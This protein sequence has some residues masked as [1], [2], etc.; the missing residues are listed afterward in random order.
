MIGGQDDVEIHRRESDHFR[1]CGEGGVPFHPRDRHGDGCR[2]SG[3]DIA[4]GQRQLPLGVGRLAA[5]IAAGDVVVLDGD[6]GAVNQAGIAGSPHNG[7]VDTRLGEGDIELGAEV[8]LG[9]GDGVVHQ[10]GEGLGL[11]RR[12]ALTFQET[13]IHGLI[14]HQVLD[15]GQEIHIEIVLIKGVEEGGGREGHQADIRIGGPGRRI[16]LEAG[17]LTVF[18]D[19][20]GLKP[21]Y[22]GNEVL[23]DRAHI[24]FQQ[25]GDEDAKD[26]GGGIDVLVIQHLAD[27]AAGDVGPQEEFLTIFR[28]A[29][30]IAVQ[31][32]RNGQKV[33]AVGVR[34]CGEG[35]PQ[36]I[37]KPGFEGPLNICGALAQARQDLIG[38]VGQIGPVQF[39][40]FEE[41]RQ[42]G[43]IYGVGAFQRITDDEVA[44]G[45]GKG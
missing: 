9:A 37:G 31:I 22:V 44:A 36:P 39:A 6:D 33:F 35:L 26:G 1:R 41:I 7:H 10:I 15:G 8:G 27:A 32:G 4:E 42:G 16:Y 24:C 3:R 5:A 28:L 19:E 34:N 14:I 20:L 45:V 2:R 23:L 11:I 18:Q 29:A 17:Q 12:H 25:R 30:H 13:G 38:Q 43:G 40:V 21:L